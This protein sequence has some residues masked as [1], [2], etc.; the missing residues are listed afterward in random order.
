MT[1]T[2]LNFTGATAVK[3]GTTAG[4]I[5]SDTAT[6]IVATSPA[7][8]T[9]KVN[10]TVTTAKGTSATT[11]ADKFTF[12][13]VVK[14]STTNLAANATT[15]TITGF[16]FSTTASN[17]QVTFSGGVTGTV[18]SATATTLT[19]TSLKGLIAGKLTASAT[20]SGIS[21]G[22]AVQVATVT[23]VVTV[24]ATALSATATSLVIHG[25]GFSTTA[26]NN[27]V[28]FNGGTTGTVSSATAT[29]LTVTNITGLVGG[30]L[31]AIVT[32]NSVSSGAAVEVATV[33]PVVTASTAALKVNATSLVIHGFGFST[34]PANNAVTIQQ[35]HDR[36]GNQRHQDSIDRHQPE[37]PQARCTHRQVKVNG[38]SSGTAKEVA[39]VV[40]VVTVSTTNL[41]ANATS[42]TIHGFGFSTTAANDKVTFSGGAHRDASPPPR[43]PR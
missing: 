43:P 34:T 5:V 35:R 18:T 37:G 26:A 2:G 31:L 3:F 27:K 13:P 39:Q 38:T 20:V 41:A 24:S 32:S 29:T 9:G 6:Q 36:Q 4:T 22:A 7:L 14:V 12:D 33:T 8:S 21:S 11:S 25:F 17:D 30:G 42:L 10:I 19:V 15:M 40:P 1:I 28:A 23:P 16:G